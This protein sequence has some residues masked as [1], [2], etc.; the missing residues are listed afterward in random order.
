M[1]YDITAKAGGLGPTMLACKSG[2]ATMAAPSRHD[3]A[4][5]GGARR[6]D[7]ARKIQPV[8]SSRSSRAHLGVLATALSN[9][10]PTQIAGVDKPLILGRLS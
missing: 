5:V 8:V 7:R 9:R 2:G 4:P 6:L 10:W 1:E 3:P